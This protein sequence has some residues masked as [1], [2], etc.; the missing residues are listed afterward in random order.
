MKILR[1]ILQGLPCDVSGADSVDIEDI[2]FDS[3]RVK[4]GALFVALKGVHQD[5]HAHVAEAIRSG[6][7]AVL[8]QD[9]VPTNGVTRVRVKDALQALA[10]IAVR[11]WDNPSH[12]LRMI[13]ITGT[14]GKTT[15]SYLIESI[16]SAAGW[17]TGVMGTINYR[18]GRH[19]EPAPNTTPF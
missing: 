4:P 5:G 18:F 9:D 14:N 3:R 16:F 11:F 15:T 12:A 19:Q 6:A 17:P 10:H 2:V 7:R 1:S 8:V 13:G